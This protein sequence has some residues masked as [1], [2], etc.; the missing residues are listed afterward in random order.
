MNAV[1]TGASGGIGR[2]IIEELTAK[3]INV[4]VCAKKA[5]KQFEEEM[6][7]LTQQYKVWIK[8]VYFDLMDSNAVKTAGK[9]ILDEKKSIDILVLNAGISITG[10]LRMTRIDDM[11]HTMEVNFFSQMEIIQ[12]LSKAMIRQRSGCIV[13]IGSTSGS[14]HAEKGGIPYGSSK[15]A[16]MFATRCIAN[17]LAE[18]GI[19]ANSVSPRLIDTKMWQSRPEEIRSEAI[20]KNMMKRMGRP[21]EVAKVVSFLVSDDASYITGANIDVAGGA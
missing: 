17:E 20:G 21:E 7:S 14:L 4:W 1:V 10:L 12:I 16:L 2:A 18:Y 11:R 15:A 13:T 6:R 9:E 3:G 8:P 5:D 19:R